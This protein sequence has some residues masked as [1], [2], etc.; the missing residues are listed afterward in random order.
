MG[1]VLTV[2]IVILSLAMIALVLMQKS[3][4]GGLASNFASGNQILGVRKTTEAVEKVTWILVAI[5]VVLCVASSAV[6]K[7]GVATNSEI[8]DQVELPAT[9]GEME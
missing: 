7:S 2:V 5:I 6:S 4:G 8:S 3:K 1:S 9:P